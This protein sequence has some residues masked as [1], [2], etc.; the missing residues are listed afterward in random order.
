MTPPTQPDLLPTE[1]IF[2][3][4]PANYVI[5]LKDYHL[6]STWFRALMPLIGMGS[7]EAIGGMLYLT[8]YRLIF[9]AHALNRVRG[10]FSIFLPTIRH[11]QNASVPV[12]RKIRITTGRQ[13]FD[14]VVW[15][16]PTLLT[17]IRQAQSVLDHSQQQNL[18][19]LVVANLDICV[20][21]PEMRQ[22]AEALI[23][24]TSRDLSELNVQN[25]FD[26][27]QLL[28]VQELLQCTYP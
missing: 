5:R 17:A 11:L 15:G 22:E 18:R 6:S 20:Q 24:D 10:T 19:Q 2:L 7:R 28:T 4:K 21:S 27:L 8:N 25:S 3:A 12:I 14:F 9:E 26:V 23:L 16:I 13:T 1:E